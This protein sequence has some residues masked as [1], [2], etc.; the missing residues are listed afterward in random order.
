[1][2]EQPL[3]L[4]YRLTCAAGESPEAKARDIALEQTVELPEGCFGPEIE[5]TV[6]GTL[7]RLEACGESVWKA[8]IVYDPLTI[9]D[10]ALQ[11][12]NLLFGNISLKNGIRVERVE[13]P[14]SVLRRLGG[15]RHGIDGVRRLCGGAG[16]RPLLCAALKPM[17]LSSDR[18]A[19]ICEQFVAG[20]ADIV[21][22][23][24]GLADQ[25]SA[26]FEAR[27]ERC[28]EAVQR[29]NRKA[30]STSLYFPNL[31]CGPDRLPK[32][33]ELAEQAGCKGILISPLLVGLETVRWI[34]RST[35]FAILSHP[36]L[37]GA[38]FH[39]SHGIAPELLLGE[40]FRIV[41]SD[42]VIYPNPGGRFPLGEES[43][44]AIDDGLRGPLGDLLPSFPVPGG[45]IDAERVP[46][47]IKRHGPDT[48]FL[49]GGS[50]YAQPD[51]TAATRR[52]AR[53]LARSDV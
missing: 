18:L 46:Y 32:R 53:S 26:P 52:L 12:L 33:L 22:D 21:K 51:L 29:A 42:G 15:P 17:G 4:H 44:A 43:C 2:Q 9:G 30:G 16:D 40:L 41:G 36:A 20:G 34:A 5:A 47:W 8:V 50:L 11:L 38:Y 24:H 45:G 28:Q 48:M 6:V 31:T 1:M 19:G 7:E 37:S 3:R 23:D 49:I 10:D 13:W 39:P 35:G 27:L 14:A 25:E